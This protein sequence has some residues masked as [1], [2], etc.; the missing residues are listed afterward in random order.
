MSVDVQKWQWLLCTSGTETAQPAALRLGGWHVVLGE[1]TSCCR[2]EDSSGQIIGCLIG[3]PIDIHAKSLLTEAVRLPWPASLI[4]AASFE[5]WLYD[6]GGNFAAI[7]AC[8]AL[9]RIYPSA[10]RTFVYADDAP[11]A[12]AT[13]ASL[14]P[15]DDYFARLDRE[16]YTVMEIEDGGWLPAGITCHRGVSRLLPNHYLDLDR[17]QPV[18]QWSGPDG[19]AAD[20][21]A[22]VADI[23]ARVSAVLTAV[24]ARYPSF[25]AFT[26]GRDSRAILAAGRH[27]A[28]RLVPFTISVKGLQSPDIE[29]A[30]EV[31]RGVGLPHWILEERTSTP[32]E[33]E[34]FLYRVGH[35]TAGGANLLMHPT[36]WS[37]DP[38]SAV[39]TGI[40]GEVG[41]G[42]FWNPGDT[43]QTRLTTESLL[44]RMNMKPLPRLVTAVGAWLRGV[45]QHDTLRILDLAYLE[46]RLGCWSTPAHYSNPDGPVHF[47]PLDQRAIVAAQWSLPDDWRRSG[48]FVEAMIEHGWPELMAWPFNRYDG[49]RQLLY[50]SRKLMSAQ[51]IRKKIR[52]HLV[53]RLS[54]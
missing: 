10:T 19:L 42:F 54:A 7:V 47:G 35:C 16:L 11:M 34:R 6:L 2:I 53:A 41:R 40:N 5:T 46:L 30:N 36:I 9:N 21:A 44:A 50:L 24:A 4:D 14:M 20:P 27:L 26:G 8:G 1:G 33:R 25:L 15:R 37:L 52:R 38:A 51:T 22:T 17:W 18:R 12:A 32:A 13:A 49:I 3:E 23:S 28:D 29:I 43:R 39:I 48:I 31:C 45:E